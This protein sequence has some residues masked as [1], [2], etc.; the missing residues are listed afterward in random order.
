M[1]K[2]QNKIARKYRVTSNDE[3]NQNRLKNSQE[4]RVE[5]NQTN[6]VILDDQL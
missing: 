2:G 6:M 4:H 5:G 3:Q 1:I